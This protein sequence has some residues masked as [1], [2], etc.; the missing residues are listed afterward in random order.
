M[1][2]AATLGRSLHPAS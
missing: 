1:R 2:L